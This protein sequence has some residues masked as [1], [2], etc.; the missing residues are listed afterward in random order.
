MLMSTSSLLFALAILLC[1]ITVSAAPV[2][3]RYP[4]SLPQ[5]DV[6]GT[7]V[8]AA[9]AA[10]NRTLASITMSQSLPGMIAHITYNQQ[11]LFSQGFGRFDPFNATS[12]PPNAHSLYRVASITK[13]FTS[14]LLL[15]LRDRNQ[16]QLD[17]A[18]HALLPAF[19]VNTNPLAPTKR[20]ITLRQLASHTSGLARENPCGWLAC[21]LT[22]MLNML[23]QQYTVLPQ[24]ARPHYSNLGFTL[25]GRALESVVKMSYED[26]MN[27]VF[28][29]QIGLAEST[30]TYDDS[31]KARLAVGVI[32]G[33]SPAPVYPGSIGVDNPCGGLF[34]SAHDIGNYMKLMFSNETSSALDRS[35][36]NE[37]LTAT[38]LFNDGVGAFGLPWEYGY[39]AAHSVWYLSKAG[40]WDGYRSQILIIPPY[41][42][43][44]FVSVQLSDVDDSS[45]YTDTIV[46]LVL[47]ALIQVIEPLQPPPTLPPHPDV[48]VGTYEGDVHVTYN[49]SAGILHSDGFGDLQ[50]SFITRSSGGNGVLD[51]FQVTVMDAYSESCRGLNDGA[52]QEMMYFVMTLEQG[53][54]VP[55]AIMF[56]G[57]TVNKRKQTK[58]TKTATE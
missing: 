19:Q 48:Y 16:L 5:F 10:V 43:G 40:E 50:L 34:A 32:D 3:P 2:C 1:A 12:E 38:S 41:K 55:T 33:G 22:V 31:T 47:P 58:Q 56:M 26:Y 57:S 4:S 44:V 54:Y 11:T 6:N 21:N 17:D 53:Q 42:L 15:S 51:M 24:Y 8:A 13:T 14:L 46:N 36:L 49:A 9:L 27:S 37:F 30:F 7:P 35:T 18:V 45:V 52:D 39:N 28:L 20:P 25:L 29:P 23:S